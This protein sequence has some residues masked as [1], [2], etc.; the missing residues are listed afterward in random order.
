MLQ[1][2]ACAAVCHAAFVARCGAELPAMAAARSPEAQPAQRKGT[3]KATT[4]TSKGPAATV[5]EDTPPAATDAVSPR[6]AADADAASEVRSPRDDAD[7]KEWA[8]PSPQPRQDD[9][10]EQAARV[11]VEVLRA[12]T[13]EDSAQAAK[14]REP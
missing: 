9:A 12:V 13:A 14:K 1:L 10:A 6:R 7:E 2:A 4:T 3:S 11:A 8:M 5:P